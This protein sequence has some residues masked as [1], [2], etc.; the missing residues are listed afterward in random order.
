MN[1]FVKTAIGAATLAIVA[2]NYLSKP[3]VLK[4][5]FAPQAAPIPAAVTP[6]PAQP[7]VE[8]Q[9]QRQDQAPS[10]EPVVQQAEP[11]PAV[12]PPPVVDTP[13]PSDEP[14]QNLSSMMKFDPGRARETR[15]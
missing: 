13:P 12:Q 4:R 3:D 5:Q 6:A 9:T 8:P 2:T 10:Y 1:L 14:P 15:N 7:A 11:P